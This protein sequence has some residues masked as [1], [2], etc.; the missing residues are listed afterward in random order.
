[1][2]SN[3]PYESTNASQGIMCFRA[4]QPNELDRRPSHPS[5]RISRFTLASN[6]TGMMCDVTTA[7]ERIAA[8]GD[9]GGPGLQTACM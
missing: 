6:G 3:S 2:I 9:F 4:G 8:V 7:H 1:M 5:F